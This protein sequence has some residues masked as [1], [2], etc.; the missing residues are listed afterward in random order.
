MVEQQPSHHPIHLLSLPRV[1]T[2]HYM[3]EADRHS[4]PLAFLRQSY[5]PPSPTGFVI[6]VWACQVI[7]P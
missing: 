3:Y 4:A 5:I 2:Q 7:S 6:E 1:E